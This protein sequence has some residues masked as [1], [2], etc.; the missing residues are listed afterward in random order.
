MRLS[1]KF[2]F[3]LIIPFMLACSLLTP[4]EPA[5]IVTK[6]T[7]TPRPT[8][9]PTQP[10]DRVAQ[11]ATTEAQQNETATAQAIETQA[12]ATDTPVPPTDTPVPVEPTAT[13]TPIPPTD[14]PIPPTN[15]PAPPPPPTNTPV[16]PTPAGPVIGQFG[17]SGKVTARDKTTF[18]VGEKAFFVYAATNHTN[19]PVSFV[20]LGIKASNGQFNTS[21]INPDVIPA[22]AVF[23]H[24][25]GLTFDVPGTY[26]VFLAICYA[27][28]DGAGAVWEEYQDGA[29][30]ITVQ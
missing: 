25:D 19:A 8:F 1:S 21:W 12:A 2:A 10:I 9:T 16:P 29:A 15:T 5:P 27:N 30:T 4:A 14:T 6:A 3:L 13:E 24:D 23:Q 26:Q 20:K 18:A 7:N 22:N 17:I 11:A 28:C